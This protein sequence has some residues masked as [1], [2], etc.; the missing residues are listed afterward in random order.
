MEI[1]FFCIKMVYTIIKPLNDYVFRPLYK[2]ARK[3]GLSER[4]SL[5]VSHIPGA[6]LESAGFWVFDW[7]VGLGVFLAS[8]AIF[9]TV[10]YKI[11]Q[12]KVSARRNEVKPSELENKIEE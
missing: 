4:A 7:R 12:N 5:Y 6:A 8:E 1:R 2:A 10:I 9:P 11:H 3:G